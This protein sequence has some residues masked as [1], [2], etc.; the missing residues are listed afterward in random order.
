MCNSFKLKLL[1][2]LSLSCSLVAMAKPLGSQL[3]M[4]SAEP[5]DFSRLIHNYG[6][7]LVVT[8]KETIVWRGYLAKADILRGDGFFLSGPYEDPLRLL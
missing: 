2:P 4:V 8:Y 5:L 3:W 6:D 1:F 7:F